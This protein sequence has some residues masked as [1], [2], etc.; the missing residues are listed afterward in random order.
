MLLR[1]TNFD[2]R[3]EKT[4][5]TGWRVRCQS[6]AGEASG[7]FDL[8][9]AGSRTMRTPSGGSSRDI[10][11]TGLPSDQVPP[12]AAGPA[13]LRTKGDRLFRALIAGSVKT[14]FDRC[15]E[16][17]SGKTNQALRLRL[18]FDTEDPEC[19]QLQELPWELLYCRET[20]LFLA[21]SRSFS[22]VRF[23]EAPLP[24]APLSTQPPLK[25]LLLAASPRDLPR[26]DLKREQRLIRQACSETKDLD[27]DT[28]DGPDALGFRRRLLRNSYHILHYMG[29]GEL[30]ELTETG[31]LLF[32][33]SDGKRK[34][35]GSDALALRLRGPEGPR[36]VV[37]NACKT[38]QGSTSATPDEPFLGVAQ[39]LVLTG[40]PAVVAMRRPIS[41]PA[42]I[43]FA[44]ELYRSLA[45]GDPVDA[46]VTEGRLAISER[47][48]GTAEW[49]IPALFLRVDD[50]RL[51]DL[52]R[53]AHQVPTPDTHV[54][55]EDVQGEEE[56]VFGVIRNGPG[57]RGADHVRIHGV[58]G[59][60]NVVVGVMDSRKE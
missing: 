30:D 57:P 1:Y 12:N 42:A 2:L 10:E 28:L 7:S 14:L 4:D 9:L 38:A 46:A 17:V 48:P 41:D 19:R 53:P 45:A 13:A 31:Q 6:P 34:A 32:E 59:R 56:K 40:V 5:A 50:S 11:Y 8:D 26:L 15:R 39:S 22:V 49:T 29:H 37:L 16:Q 25:A 23:L 27:I 36:F 55:I 35:L 24:H 3:I 33:G 18:R 44:E 21:L 58:R 20:R 52:P 54:E 43:G 47:S 51:L 60:R